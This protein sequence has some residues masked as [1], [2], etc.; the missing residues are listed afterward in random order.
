MVGLAGI[1]YQAFDKKRSLAMQSKSQ[2][3]PMNVPVA[4]PT[5]PQAFT[6]VELLVVITIIGILAALITVAA[7]GALKK[8]H[9]T[10]IKLEL[11]QISQG[12]E[13]SRNKMGGAYP[14]NCQVDD[15]SDIGAEGPS[16]PINEAQ[17]LTDLK[18]YFK[19][20]FPRSRESD[21]LLRALVGLSST[22]SDSGDYLQVLPGG[23]SA[24][25]AIV[26]W[27]GGF[28]SDPKY[29]ISGDGGPAYDITA[30]GKGNLNNRQLEPLDRKWI[31]P[32]ATTRLLP[33][34]DDN[35]FDETNSRFIEYVSPITINGTRQI[36]RIN[37]WQYVPKKSEQPYLYFDV[38]RHPALDTSV[39]LTSPTATYDPPAATRLTGLGPGGNGLPVY[40]IKKLGESTSTPIQ[41]AN[42]DKFQ[43]LHAGIDDEWG[44]FSKMT[45]LTLSTNDPT[46]YL[47]FPTGPFTGEVA[48][49]IVNFSESTLAGSQK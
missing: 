15:N 44:D 5:P 49:T 35:Y 20:A 22:G 13:D 11:D 27:L 3:N 45:T 16:F 24:G 40:A 23:I 37:F 30:N 46:K 21:N 31:F 28:S 32:F 18:R 34:K 47:L 33:R 10:E 29:P 17:V 12:V 41:F 8:A 38:S 14:P 42:Q 19:Q 1:Q 9:Q 25:E 7:A 36:R 26:F 48:D 39:S 4:K 2:Q 43:I 6:L